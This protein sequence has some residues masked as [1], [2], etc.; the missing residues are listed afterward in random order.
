MEVAQ[1]SQREAPRPEHAK[2]A[3]WA[4]RAA[5]SREAASTDRGR[6]SSLGSY[7]ASTLSL[8]AR[9]SLT[10]ATGKDDKKI[11]VAPHAHARRARQGHRG[12]AERV[13]ERRRQAL[14]RHQRR[15]GPRDRRHRTRVPRRS[16]SRDREGRAARPDRRG[17]LG[18]PFDGRVDALF[19]RVVFGDGSHVP[20]VALPG[21]AHQ[22]ASVRGGSG[23]CRPCAKPLSSGFRRRSTPSGGLT[24]GLSFPV[25]PQFCPADRALSRHRPRKDARLPGLLW[26]STPKFAR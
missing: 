24:T 11:G 8:A 14:P 5:R 13:A 23:G 20:T 2:R 26:R 19:S 21:G 1:Q 10:M 15:R 7:R 12:P 6:A 18:D 3:I 17:A 25:D 9:P 4:G 22:Q 16:A